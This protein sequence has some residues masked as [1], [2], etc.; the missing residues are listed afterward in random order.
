MFTGIIT[1]IGTIS[2][3]TKPGDTRI[4]IKT[5]YDVDGIDI[6]ASIACNGI[7]LTVVEKYKD[8]ISFEASE[9]T[10]K[11]TTLKNWEVGSKIN[12]ERA[13]KLGDEF[14]GHMVSGHVDG[15]SEIIS[16][17]KIKDSREI[18]FSIPEGLESFIAKKGSV[19]IDGVSLT[20]NDVSEDRFSI[21]IIPHTWDNTI[22]FKQDVGVQVNLE[23]D[24]VARYISRAMEVSRY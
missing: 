22:F 16:I 8:K 11:C 12:L 24:L 5:S 18:I 17:N 15:V 23:I 9:E 2:E 10:I 4:V 20:I 1:D 13:L 19:A 21:N 6:G 14:G 7:C 3:I